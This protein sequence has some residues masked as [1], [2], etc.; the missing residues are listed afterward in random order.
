MQ[1]N[2]LKFVI[3][4]IK[5]AEDTSKRVVTR[6]YSGNLWVFFFYSKDSCHLKFSWADSIQ[7]NTVRKPSNLK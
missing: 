2:D 1:N 5:H 6:K 7:E 3:T 4:T